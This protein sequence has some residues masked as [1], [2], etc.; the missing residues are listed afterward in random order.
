MFVDRGLSVYSI[1]TFI[2]ST[3][4]KVYYLQSF[5]CYKNTTSTLI[6]FTKNVKRCFTKCINVK[7]Y[8]SLIS[9]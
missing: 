7:N 4:L 3:L 9:Y 5:T 6:S 8:Y 2:I 1:S